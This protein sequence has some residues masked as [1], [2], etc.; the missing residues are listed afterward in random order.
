MENKTEGVE[1]KMYSAYNIVNPGPTSPKE[2]H[3]L[4]N[5]LWNDFKLIYMIFLRV[6]DVSL[7]TYQ[8][9]YRNGYHN[10]DGNISLDKKNFIKI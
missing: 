3:G 7:I 6:E 1:D 2:A 5:H 10:L 4:N 9:K 8:W